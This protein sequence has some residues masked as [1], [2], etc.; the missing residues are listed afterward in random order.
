MVF[1]SLKVRY[2]REMEGSLEMWYKE[3]NYSE[4]NSTDRRDTGW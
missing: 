2:N 3:E 1:L 4:R